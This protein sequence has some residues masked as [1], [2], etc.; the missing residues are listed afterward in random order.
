MNSPETS[1]RNAAFESLKPHKPITFEIATA[2][3]PL[4]HADCCTSV[5]AIW[6]I[7]KEHTYLESKQEHIPRGR[8]AAIELVVSASGN[9]RIEQRGGQKRGGLGG[10]GPGGENRAD[11]AGAHWPDPWRNPGGRGGMG[12]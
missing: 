5:D 6:G 1:F 7:Y 12:G 8:A 11:M 3:D 9:I 4:T 2:R 10:G